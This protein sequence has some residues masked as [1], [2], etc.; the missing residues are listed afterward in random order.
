MT[1]DPSDS[2]ESGDDDMLSRAFER[3]APEMRPLLAAALARAAVERYRDWAAR[4]T[5]ERYRFRLLA[6]AEREEEIIGAIAAV[7]RDAA[8]IEREILEN[9]RDLARIDADAFRDLSIAE[10]LLIQTGR[11]QFASARWRVLAREAREPAR[12]RVFLACADLEEINAVV[13]E[14]T[15]RAGLRDAKPSNDDGDC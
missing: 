8:A 5:S 1:N 4:F 13:L 11:A 12:R 15:V 14:V 10:Q 7:H 3:L 6:C 2:R 9:H